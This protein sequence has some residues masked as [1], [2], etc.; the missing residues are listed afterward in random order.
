MAKMVIRSPSSVNF[1]RVFQTF[2]DDP[3]FQK[4]L[5][6]ANVIILPRM[7]VLH[8]T[9]PVFEADTR[10]LFRYLRDHSPDN[11]RVEVAIRDEDYLELVVHADVLELGK[12]LVETF[13]APLL[14]TI[15]GNYISERLKHRGTAESPETTTVRAELIL[16]NKDG[17]SVSFKYDGPATTFEKVLG[18]EIREFVREVKGGNLRE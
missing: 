2:V 4:Q 3:D 7:G 1:D 8:Y 9:G 13:V 6:Q 17:S 10:E 16:A 11:L 5:M 18:G 15:L 12:I 14:V